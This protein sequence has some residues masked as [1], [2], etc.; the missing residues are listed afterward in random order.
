MINF[1]TTEVVQWVVLFV[2]ILMDQWYILW[3]LFMFLVINTFFC[4]MY[5]TD[6]S[7][8]LGSLTCILLPISL[9]SSPFTTLCFVFCFFILLKFFALIVC[10]GR[11]TVSLWLVSRNKFLHASLPPSSPCKCLTSE[12]TFW[13]F[14]VSSQI[15]RS[16]KWR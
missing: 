6:F 9:W 15:P 8:Y 14:L 11:G 7:T 3:L 16:A 10:R 2:W 4:F 5:L 13:L 12:T 1:L